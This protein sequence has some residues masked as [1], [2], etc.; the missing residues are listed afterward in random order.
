MESTPL[1]VLVVSLFTANR[2]TLC[3][4]VLF[5]SALLNFPSTLFWALKTSKHANSVQF[6]E[7]LSVLF[8]CLF[9]PHHH[10]C[11]ITKKAL[12]KI[13]KRHS[14]YRWDPPARGNV[15]TLPVLL[16][17]TRHFILRANSIFFHRSYRFISLFRRLVAF[18]WGDWWQLR[19]QTRPHLI[20]HKPLG[21]QM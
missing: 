15:R 5:V 10:H 2:E 3:I 12:E 1:R 9:E 11:L 6:Q 16:N 13:P 7:H 21:G 14:A 18:L 20:T 19:G 4:T 17:I 8:V